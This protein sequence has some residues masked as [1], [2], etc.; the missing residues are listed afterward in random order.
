MQDESSKYLLNMSY[1]EIYNGEIYGLL[2]EKNIIAKGTKTNAVVGTFRESLRL[3]NLQDKR[4]YVDSRK[5]RVKSAEH[6][7]ELAQQAS[8][9]R[10]TSSN[11]INSD[12]SRSHCI[13]QL[14]VRI[15]SPDHSS[16][17]NNDKKDKLV[18][19]W[20]VDLAG[21]E[22]SKRT[23]AVPYSTRQQEASQNNLFTI[24]PMRCLNI[25]GRNQSASTTAE[26]VPFR[27]FKFT[28][29]FMNHL[30]G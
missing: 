3:V 8:T 16:V 4:L 25:M 29:L 21:S 18:T 13:C 26:V 17:T 6:R 19:V 12:S 5:R 23:V 20:I 9:K 10:H 2:P 1:M 24:T 11:S 7:L 14:E 30:T 22:R 27:D 28:N 15:E